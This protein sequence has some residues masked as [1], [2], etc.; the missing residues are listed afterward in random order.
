V[1]GMLA[2]SKK[3]SFDE[4]N[5]GDSRGRAEDLRD[6]TTTLN[7]ATDVLIGAAVVSAG[8]T[9]YLY[10]SR[11]TVAKSQASIEWT[12]VVTATSGL[13]SASGRF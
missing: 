5:T 13:F 4:A 2:L 11:P 6:S 10:L 3:S 1:T 9:A 12:P 8:I 7:L